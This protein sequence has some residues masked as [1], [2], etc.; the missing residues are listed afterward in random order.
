MS[1]SVLWGSGQVYLASN[2]VN[3]SITHHYP[4]APSVP[5][6]SLLCLQGCESSSI[7]GFASVT[8]FGELNS[9]SDRILV[10][11]SGCHISR[12]QKGDFLPWVPL[13]KIKNVE[14]EFSQGANL[15]DAALLC[16]LSLETK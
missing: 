12:L 2:M 13:R 9:E 3:L 10:E 1:F 5:E 6:L 4:V 7:R 8:E 11:H 14:K 15:S 16:R